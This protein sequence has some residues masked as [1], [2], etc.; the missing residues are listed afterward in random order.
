[1][2]ATLGV[3]LVEPYNPWGLAFAFPAFLL[4]FKFGKDLLGFKCGED[5]VSEAHQSRVYRT[6]PQRVFLYAIPY[7]AIWHFVAYNQSGASFLLLVVCSFPLGLYLGR[8][9][10]FAREVNNEA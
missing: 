10:R 8:L 6:T 1:M 5:P 9:W 3:M 2:I 4:G 7:F